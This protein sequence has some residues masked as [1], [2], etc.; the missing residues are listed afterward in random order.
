MVG[1]EV[2]IEVVAGGVA[3]VWRLARLGASFFWRQ[4]LNRQD[5]P[6]R[7]TSHNEPARASSKEMMLALENA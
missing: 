3:I 4:S 6:P 1:G 7:R 2:G 5:G